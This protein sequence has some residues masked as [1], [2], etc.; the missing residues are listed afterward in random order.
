MFEFPRAAELNKRIPKQKFYENMSIT[1]AMKK[2]FAEQIKEIKWAYKLSQD[3]IN[4]NCGQTVSEIQIFKVMLNGNKLDISA[5]KQID[6]VIPYNN[7]YILEYSD[8]YQ[9]WLCHKDG[10]FIK[11]FHTEWQTENELRLKIEGISLDEVYENFILQVSGI[12]KD[13]AMPLTAQ[14]KSME[15]TEKL[16]KEIARLEKQARAEKQPKK[17]FELVQKIKELKLRSEK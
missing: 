5:I 17:K 1:A 8:K 16:Q 13:K 12:K 2:I 11:Y 10:G 6:K 7:V 4:I 3:T 15:Q 9:I 14:I